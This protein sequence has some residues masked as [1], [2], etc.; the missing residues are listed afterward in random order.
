MSFR[1]TRR[2]LLG[3]LLASPLL[4]A[5]P[6]PSSSLHLVRKGDDDYATA[7]INKNRAVTSLP[8]AVAYAFDERD[9]IA[10]LRYA[11]DAGLSI[12]VRSGGH[13]YEGFSTNNNG[14]VI[15][16]SRFDGIAVDRK[17]GSCRVAPGVLLRTLYHRLFTEASAS[18]PAGSCGTVGVAGLT[19][20]GG[21][22][23][24]GRMH[25]LLCD[26]LRAVRLVDAAGTV[27]TS[28][29]DPDLL[30]A[31]CGGG[32]GNFGIVTE[33]VFDLV[34]VPATVTTFSLNPGW[35]AV[36][37]RAATLAFTQSAPKL[38]DEIAATLLLSRNENAVDLF[39]LS[40]LGESPTRAALREIVR[41]IGGTLTTARVPYL[42]AVELGA[43]N[44]DD[45]A[46][47]K[48]T[49]SFLKDPLS[50]DG[51]DAVIQALNAPHSGLVQLELFGGAI[52]K[53]RQDASA[54][55]HRDKSVLIQY[56]NYWRDPARGQAESSWVSNAFATVDPHTT[57][58]SYRNYCD[59]ALTDWPVRYYGANY[60]RL[61]QI[62]ARLDSQNRFS[63]PQSIRLP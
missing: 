40:L 48:M 50:G 31:C 41:A 45:V 19:L 57:M 6:S 60:A 20:G 10:A 42:E 24:L 25:G 46:C 34:A 11:K 15:D 59:L 5:V 37:A 36:V 8:Q 29:P 32:G 43:G 18:L 4:A 16:L 26:R 44:D 54:F 2:A 63:Y 14:L 17:D 49:S 35:N 55:W 21:F 52:A 7:R 47:W 33:F 56:Q 51:C 30:W 3:S 22:G 38:P 62:K 9:V 28:A 27:R 53:L 13:D 58:S 23:P 39:G 61:Q 12:S 1:L